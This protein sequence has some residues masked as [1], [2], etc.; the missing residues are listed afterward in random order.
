M[1]LT[2]QYKEKYTVKIPGTD[3]LISKHDSANIEQDL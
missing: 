2:E 3:I 1:P